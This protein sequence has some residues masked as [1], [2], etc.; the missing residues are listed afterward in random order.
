[1]CV[2][3]ECRYSCGIVG[4]TARDQKRHEDKMCPNRPGADD[5]ICIFCDEL[6]T[7]HTIDRHYTESCPHRS[8]RCEACGQK[9]IR[10]NELMQHT[11]N[12]CPF[13]LKSCSLGCG[14]MLLRRDIVKHTDTECPNRIVE[15][16]FLCGIKDL[17]A[18]DQQQHQEAHFD[19]LRPLDGS[20]RLGI[21]HNA[22]SAL[23]DSNVSNDMICQKC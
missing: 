12:E 9:N 3:Q 2:P 16:E 22:Q 19:N 20:T 6:C 11:L 10:V 1:M 17:K 13:T 4:L 8:V 15:C 5:V 18:R 14:A 23:N 21:T 7:R